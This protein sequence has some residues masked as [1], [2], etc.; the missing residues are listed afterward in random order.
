M[1]CS[2]C[3]ASLRWNQGHRHVCDSERK[4]DFE[5]FQHR[6]ELDAFEAELDHFLATPRGR[7]EQWYAE[8]E[9][10]QSR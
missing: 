7:F 6:E 4:L 5:L 3:G 8:R 2:E 10:R 1:P 9:R